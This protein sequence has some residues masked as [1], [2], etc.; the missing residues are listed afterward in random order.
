MFCVINLQEAALEQKLQK[1]IAGICGAFQIVE[2]RQAE[3]EKDVQAQ[4]ERLR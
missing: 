3:L 4:S 1:D 2:H